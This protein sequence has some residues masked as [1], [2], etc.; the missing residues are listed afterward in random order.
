MP[1]NP[2]ATTGSRRASGKRDT[3]TAVPGWWSEL[4]AALRDKDFTSHALFHHLGVEERGDVRP[5]RY[6]LVLWQAKSEGYLEGTK[7]ERIGGRVPSRLL[8]AAK[9]KTGITS[10]TEL[11]EYALSKVALEDDYG[12]RLL[13]RKGRVPDDVE[14]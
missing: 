5:I 7:A 13:S 12:P 3:R 10:Q 2:T 11:I 6:V 14:L 8:S 4:R 9:E 1:R